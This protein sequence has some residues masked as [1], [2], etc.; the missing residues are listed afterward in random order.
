MLSKKLEEALNN[1]INE[2][3]YSSYLY[4]SMASWFESQNLSGFANWM[5]IQSE[6]EYLHARK[7]YEYINNAGGRVVFE[8]IKTPQKEWN[9]IEEIFQDTFDHENHI[10][11]C[12]NELASLAIDEKDHATNSFL[13]WFV[14][15][16]VEEVAIAD[17]IL[18][19]IKM[20]GE[21]KQG[22][23]MLDREM[24]SRAPVIPDIQQ[25]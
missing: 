7:F 11:N 2:E 3:L 16:Q 6:E 18:H 12:V 22:I 25:N 10:T 4:W 24:K 23:F 8:A 14:D 17:Q 5:K 9:N 1:Q 19:E 21:N 20:I 13:R 15:E